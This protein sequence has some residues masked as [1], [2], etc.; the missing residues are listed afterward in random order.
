MAELSKSDT[1]WVPKKVDQIAYAKNADGSFLGFEDQPPLSYHDGYLSAQ[2]YPFNYLEIKLTPLQQEAIDT[3]SAI[4]ND[5]DFFLEK[6]L[7]PGDIQWIHNPSLLHSRTEIFE[8]EV[9]RRADHA[10]QEIRTPV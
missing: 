9:R 3:F 4:A 6:K 8:G 5:P 10:W 1:W 7:E 2:F